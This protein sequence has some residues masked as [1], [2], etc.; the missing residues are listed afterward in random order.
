MHAMEGKVMGPLATEEPQGPRA[1]LANGTN[2]TD[3][4]L[5][6]SIRYRP[7]LCPL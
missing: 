1:G 5:M 4:L 7:V 3:F 2:A 6:E